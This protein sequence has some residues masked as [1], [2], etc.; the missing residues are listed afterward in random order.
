[1]Q[2]IALHFQ[3]TVGFFRLI[4]G[5]NKSDIVVGELADFAVFSP[6]RSSLSFE[7]LHFSLLVSVSEAAHYSLHQ[8][9]EKI[10]NLSHVRS[11]AC[12][13]G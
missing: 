11:E 7:F 2:F 12:A 9:A 6:C 10:Q 4:V 8:Q 1:M 5:Q 13:V 3:S